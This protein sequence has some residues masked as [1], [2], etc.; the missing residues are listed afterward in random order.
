MPVYEFRCNDCGRKVTLTYKTYADY[1]AAIPACTHCESADLTRLISRVRFKRASSVSNLLSGAMGSDDPGAQD[2]L[3]DADPRMLGRV[4]REMRDET[5]EDPG[6]E[7]DEI[8]TRL[9]RGDDPDAIEASLP[10]PPTDSPL[11]PPPAPPAPS[12]PAASDD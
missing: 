11:D 5:D 2:A 1:D 3:D 9:E 7:F 4:L 8:V 6:P 10:D 12:A